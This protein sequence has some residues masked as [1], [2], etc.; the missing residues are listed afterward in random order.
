MNV[1]WGIDG[2]VDKFFYVGGVYMRVLKFLAD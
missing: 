1:E 2:N